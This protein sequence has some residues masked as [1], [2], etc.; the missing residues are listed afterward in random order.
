MLALLKTMR[1]FEVGLNAFSLCYGHKLVG[2]IVERGD[3]NDNC[4]HLAQA[5]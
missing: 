5:F 1:A 4:P 3:L 2:T